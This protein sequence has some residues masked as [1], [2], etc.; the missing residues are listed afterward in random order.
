MPDAPRV[1]V[2]LPVRNGEAYLEEALRSL[3]EQRGPSFEIVVVD[4]GSTDGTGAILARMSDERMTVMRGAGDGIASSL[5]AALAVARGAYVARMD[6]D[7]IALPNRFAMQCAVLDDCPDVGLVHTS[8]GFIDGSGR[9]TGTLRAA[10]LDRAQQRA[11]LLDQRAG[12]PIVHPSVMMRRDAL[13]RVGGYRDLPCAQD[14]ELWLRTVDL[15]GFHAIS[16]PL[17]HYRQHDGAT[18]HTKSSLQRATHITNCVMY[19]LGAMPDDTATRAAV[20]ERV[21]AAVDEYGPAIEAGIAFRRAVRSKRPLKALGTLLNGNLRD[22]RA[23]TVSH[24]L[25]ISRIIQDRVLQ[26]MRA[27]E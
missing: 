13:H 23:V 18:S 15:W 10:H 5:N 12:K 4:D 17:L 6:A 11:V 22:P 14:H 24:A 19:R 9:V 25:R 27:A 2:L 16:E 7:D 21:A 1:S 8:A 3:F 20:M 26:D